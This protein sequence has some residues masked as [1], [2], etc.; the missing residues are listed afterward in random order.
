MG[1]DRSFRQ[2]FAGVSRLSV[3]IATSAVLVLLILPTSASAI[4]FQL[5]GFFVAEPK[6]AAFTDNADI[7]VAAGVVYYPK[8]LTPEILRYTVD[9]TRLPSW[10]PPT[11]ATPTPAG[12]G[13]RY[14][15]YPDEPSAMTTDRAGNVYVADESSDCQLR[16]K[17]CI[18]VFRPDGS[19]IRSF[20]VG[21]HELTTA[22]PGYIRGPVGGIAVDSQGF[23]YV[24]N[25]NQISKFASNGTFVKAWDE[26]AGGTKSFSPSG[27]AVD[28]ADLLY[29]SQ[30]IHC[31]SSCA[32]NP[33][34]DI[35]KYDTLGNLLGTM[36]DGYTPN[37]DDVDV[38]PDGRIYTAEESAD[39][40]SVFAPD[41]THLTSFFARYQTANGT[42]GQSASEVD[43]DDQGVIRTFTGGITAG[44]GEESG[45]IASYVE[46]LTPPTVRIVSGPPRRLAVRGKEARVKFEFSADDPLATYECSLDGGPFVACQTPYR[47]RVKRGKHTLELRGIDPV[48][49]SSAAPAE[50]RFTIAKKKRKGRG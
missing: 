17:E 44:F 8:Y 30:Q 19:L 10:N 45:G 50:H 42:E 31:G 5:S 27:I 16:I 12:N 15:G 20:G 25:R 28:A 9:G 46:D 6:A 1:R 43:V 40:I 21:G 18:F 39:R 32:Q 3:A 23:V 38:G 49:N 14:P 7:T 13:N 2:G 36:E 37:A 4:G 29:V 24:V 41:G 22:P 47:I 48:G 33:Y 35:Y 11:P 26:S 34:F